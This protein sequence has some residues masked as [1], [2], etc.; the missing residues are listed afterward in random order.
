MLSILVQ[1][2]HQALV[3]TKYN[4]YEGVFMKN[5]GFKL[6]YIITA[7][8]VIIN[9]G[10][11]IKGN[12]FSDI[13]DLPPGVLQNSVESPSGDK[14]LNI[15]LIKASI[16]VAIRGEIAQDGKSHNIFWQT[17]I[18]EVEVFWSDDDTVYINGT[19]FDS[20]DTFG[21][22]SRRGYSP[23]DEGSLEE[24]FTKDKR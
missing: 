19:P 20:A 3:P 23:F 15:Y 11:T 21:Y 17:G 10:F 9:L 7:L 4:Y 8:V 18:D 22:D 5:L 6:I 2:L 12:L 24:N 16:G 13:N 14:K 1:A